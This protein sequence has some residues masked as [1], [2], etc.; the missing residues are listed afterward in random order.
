[1]FKNLD[2]QAGRYRIERCLSNNNDSDIALLNY[3]TEIQLN[4]S[5]LEL[6]EIGQDKKQ[7]LI[8]SLYEIGVNTL[9]I[10]VEKCKTFDSI[11]NTDIQS[12]P[13]YEYNYLCKDISR[14]Q[15]SYLNH[16]SN[17]ISIYQERYYLKIISF[18]TIN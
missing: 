16:S 3:L 7:L 15:N 13:K 11:N 2:N 17:E 14:L 5:Q 4:L 6:N 10:F 1:M 12:N 9:G 8:N 18:I